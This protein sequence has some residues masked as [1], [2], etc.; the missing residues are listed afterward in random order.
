MWHVSMM[1]Q[2]YRSRDAQGS[3][4]ATR[5]QRG[6]KRQTR[7]MAFVEIQLVEGPRRNKSNM[8]KSLEQLEANGHGHGAELQ[9]ERGS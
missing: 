1:S 7:D 3:A 6:C 8:D 2:N 5:K 9:K 4:N